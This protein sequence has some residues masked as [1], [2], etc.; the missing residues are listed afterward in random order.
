MSNGQKLTLKPVRTQHDIDR[1]EKLDGW[2]EQP[3][4]DQAA[5]LI[6]QPEPTETAAVTP[7]PKKKGKDTAKPWEI[8]VGA[9]E[10]AGKGQKSVNFK[11]PMELYLKLRWLGETTYGMDMT[12]ITIEALT[13]HTDKMI[14]ARDK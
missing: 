6:P 11:L 13:A 10:S 1:L 14:K 5:A 3:A 9:A 2:T 12:K 7:E 4:R 8:G